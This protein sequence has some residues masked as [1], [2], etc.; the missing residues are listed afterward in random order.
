MRLGVVGF[1]SERLLEL[2][3]RVGSSA[4]LE[5]LRA[6]EVVRQRVFGTVPDLHLGAADVHLHRVPR[7][8]P[9]Q[10]VEVVGVAG[11]DLEPESAHF[12]R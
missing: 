2:I 3:N 5:I 9:R 6:E 12:V 1:Q 4:C 8:V 7:G 10:H 11:Q